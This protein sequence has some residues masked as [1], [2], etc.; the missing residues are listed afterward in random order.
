MLPSS[1]I[2]LA[3]PDLR[4][5]E[6]AYLAQCVTD[7]WVSSAGPFVTEFETRMADATGRRYGVA[8]VNGT[9]ALQLSITALD[10]GPGDRV[11]I[12]DWTFAATANAVHHAGAT[13]VFVD[14]SRE[15]WCLDPALTE[16]AIKEYA[17]K[18]VV[19]VHAAGHPADMNALT[20]VCRR[21][22]VVLLEDAAG[23]IGSE[24]RG[25]PVGGFGHCAAFSFNG[26]KLVTAGGGGMVVTDDEVA[27]RR[28]RHL[29]TQAR[30]GADYIHD[31]IGNN[32]RMTN[33]NAALGVAQIERLAEMVTDKRGVAA[34]YDAAFAAVNDVMPMPRCDWAATNCWMYCVELPREE[35]ARNL[36]AYLYDRRIQARMFWMALS[37]QTPY[38]KS[39]VLRSG[40]ADS[41]SGTVVSLP[42]SSQLTEAEQHR[43]IE[44][45]LSWRREN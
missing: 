35:M 24:Y 23:A 44:A 33:L 22:G 3:I 17:P 12:P 27:A 32:L 19:C 6:Q 40:V 37:R 45:V 9:A 5:N 29:S 14:V 42:C 1:F 34:R 10:I 2:P 20:D 28:I 30:P 39:P 8:L 7:N 15:S 31:A 4:G 13:P 21:H 18:A 11:V 16:Q 38:A 26:N 25:K 36:I 41:L 43:V